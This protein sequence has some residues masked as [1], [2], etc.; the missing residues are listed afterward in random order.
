[1]PMA[2][3]LH[4]RKFFCKLPYF[5]TNATSLGI[6][7][8]IWIYINMF[9]IILPSV[10]I[11]AMPYSLIIIKSNISVKLYKHTEYVT[12]FVI[13][14]R[15]NGSSH[16][17]FVLSWTRFLP[18]NLL[19]QF[20]ICYHGSGR[21]WRKRTTVAGT[22]RSLVMPGSINKPLVG[23]GVLILSLGRRR[24]TRSTNRDVGCKITGMLCVFI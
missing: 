19:V 8:Y 22:G 23:S 9:N 2:E 14:Y 4:A 5:I 16:V 10:F 3:C 13:I 20:F 15:T 18:S 11:Y 17:V 7:I 6:C 1:M 24:D 12:H 21:L